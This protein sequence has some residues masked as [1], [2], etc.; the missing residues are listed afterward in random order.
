MTNTLK[1]DLTEKL[2]KFITKRF[3][4]LKNIQFLSAAYSEYLLLDP[5]DRP[6]MNSMLRL[7]ETSFGKFEVD[8]LAVNLLDNGPEF[9][10]SLS[11]D[12]GKADHAIFCQ[13]ALSYALIE[14]KSIEIV[15][16][17]VLKFEQFNED[18]AELI[19]SYMQRKLE[20]ESVSPQK[21]PDFLK[22]SQN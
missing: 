20:W 21:L 9:L 12:A 2:E 22:I 8:T 5:N 17:E 14:I 13:F 19:F 3:S 6:P 1:K 7:L 18:D 15:Q 11:G 10:M 16:G 4:A